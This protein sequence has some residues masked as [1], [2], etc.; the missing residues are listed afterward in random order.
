MEDKREAVALALFRQIYDGSIDD[1]PT[2]P[3]RLWADLPTE[4]RGLWY[5]QADVALAAIAQPPE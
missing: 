4:K 2:F 1:D 3:D 5:H